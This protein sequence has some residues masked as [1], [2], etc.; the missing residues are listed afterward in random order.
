VRALN[1]WRINSCPSFSTTARGS[2]RR[3]QH[4]TTNE[5]LNGSYIGIDFALVEALVRQTLSGLPARSCSSFGGLRRRLLLRGEISS[6]GWTSGAHCPLLFEKDCLLGASSSYLMRALRRRGPGLARELSAAGAIR[7]LLA[8]PKPTPV[9][10]AR[11]RELF[12][13]EPPAYTAGLWRAGWLRR[14][15]KHRHHCRTT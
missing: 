12:E 6:L 9:L 1:G 5:F 11:W 13:T 3:F 2:K 14:W 10:K 4:R 8:S 7:V 15:V